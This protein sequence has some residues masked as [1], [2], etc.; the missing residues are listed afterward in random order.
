MLAETSRLGGPF[1]TFW[2]QRLSRTFSF[3][4]RRWYGQF[5]AADD[6][7]LVGRSIERECV[8]NDIEETIWHDFFRELIALGQPADAFEAIDKVLSGANAAHF[9]GT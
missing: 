6:S 7:R 2:D 3:V 9:D 5:D 4:L 8:R 1:E